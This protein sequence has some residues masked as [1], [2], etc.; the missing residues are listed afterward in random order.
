VATRRGGE[1]ELTMALEHQFKQ[2]IETAGAI[3]VKFEGGSVYFQDA[4][5][6]PIIS[7]YAFCCDRENIHLA[8][9]GQRE[10]LSIDQWEK[11]I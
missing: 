5:D 8:I 6:K 3:F 4:P 9:K 2:R 11:L 1:S 10:E 7:L